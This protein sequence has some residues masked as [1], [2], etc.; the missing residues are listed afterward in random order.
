MHDLMRDKLAPGLIA[1]GWTDGQVQGFGSAGP[2]PWCL[3]AILFHLEPRFERG[4][5]SGLPRK[6]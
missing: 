2:S 3:L 6:Y 4:T 5:A 1:W